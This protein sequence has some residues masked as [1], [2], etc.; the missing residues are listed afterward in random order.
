M[1]KKKHNID[2]K[3]NAKAANSG[4]WFAARIKAIDPKIEHRHNTT[5]LDK[6][7]K[8]RRIWTGKSGASHVANVHFPV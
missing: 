7:S 4:R 8:F 2:Q 3:S 6:W 5:A 1:N